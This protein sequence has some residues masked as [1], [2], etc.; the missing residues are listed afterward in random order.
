MEQRSR[1]CSQCRE[2]KPLESF[3]SCKTDRYGKSYYCIPCGR[4]R[5]KS[6]RENNKGLYLS[7]QRKYDKGRQKSHARRVSQS[8]VRKVQRAIKSGF[9]IK[10]P[11]VICGELKTYAHHDDYSKPL[12]VIWICQSHHQLIHSGVMSVPS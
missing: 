2:V 5:I 9:L 11:C 4:S 3:N 8:A 12:Q 10:N 6:W 7:L 1:R